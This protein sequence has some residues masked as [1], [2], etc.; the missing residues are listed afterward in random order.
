MSWQLSLLIFRTQMRLDAAKR[1]GGLLHEHAGKL[2][3]DEDWQ[4][5]VTNETGLILFVINVTGIM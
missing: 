2:L 4:M 5:D 1:I 3:E